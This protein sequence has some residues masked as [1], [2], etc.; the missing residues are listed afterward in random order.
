MLYPRGAKL[1]KGSC[2]FM[3]L[4]LN[5]VFPVVIVFS[6][7]YLLQRFNPIN[8]SSVANVSIYI[9]LPSLVFISLYEAEI[10]LDFV[11]VSI[12]FIILFILIIFIIK[13][14]AFILKWNKRVES[15]A[16]LATAFMN[17]GNYALPVIMFSLGETAMTYAIFCFVVS[18]I[19]MSLF[20]VY[21][22]SRGSRGIKMA[23]ATV[24]KMPT[25]YAVIL[26]FA[27]QKLPWSIPYALIS[28]LKVVGNAAIPTMMVLL[29]AQLSLI[30][31]KHIEW[32]RVTLLSFIRMIVSPILGFIIIWFMHIEGTVSYV[33]LIISS[34]PSSITMT[35]FSIEF[36]AE[37]RL[38]SSVTLV[39]TLVSFV[40][41]TILLNLL[42]LI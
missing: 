30:T 33:L 28:I 6:S 29:G 3:G 8:I 12:F 41:L 19:F 14:L 26:A 27:L 13:I 9:F 7:G 21:F 1:K 5:V 40:T 4:F 20:G 34:M 42:K 11:N 10:G 36:D 18:S 32:M 16:I 39:T 17:G 23:I 22:A 38:V 24:L 37:P 2:G 31:L 35:M 25:T 15:G